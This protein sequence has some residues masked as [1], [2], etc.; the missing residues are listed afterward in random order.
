M[1]SAASGRK[2]PLDLDR[3]TFGDNN[4]T[5]LANAFHSIANKSRLLRDQLPPT[6][7]KDPKPLPSI[8]TFPYSRHSSYRELCHLLEAFKPRDVWP[9]TLDPRDWLERGT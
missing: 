7:S 3:A 2:I 4:E 6:S 9:C 5:D 1:Q 8:V